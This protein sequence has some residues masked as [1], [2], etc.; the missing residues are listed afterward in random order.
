MTH[1]FPTR[2]SSD[3]YFES[4]GKDGAPVAFFS[5]EMSSEQLATR[6]LSEQTRIQSERLRRGE[7]SDD[8]FARELIPKSRL[9]E[10]VPFFIDD[11]GAISIRSEEHTSELQSLMRI[12]YTVFCLK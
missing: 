11:T 4:G 8:E 5:L 10:Q 12:S 9:L 3:L 2:R 1:F 6:I 7:V